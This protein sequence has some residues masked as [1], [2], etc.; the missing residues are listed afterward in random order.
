[1]KD[2]YD[3]WLIPGTFAFEGRVLTRATGRL[4]GA[5]AERVNQMDRGDK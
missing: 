3:L 5:G 2:Y 4:E 1:M